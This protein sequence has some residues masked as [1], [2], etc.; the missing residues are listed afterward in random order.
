MVPSSPS[1]HLGRTP[2][3]REYSEAPDLLTGNAHD[4]ESMMAQ[5]KCRSSRRHIAA[6]GTL[7]SRLTEGRAK[8]RRNPGCGSSEG[9]STVRI[10]RFVQYHSKQ[11]NSNAYPVW[12]RKSK[13]YDSAVY[14]SR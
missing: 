2:H 4:H 9:G 12:A 13:D 14:L 3:S 11:G 10:N 8:A 1:D 7:D 5:A 6:P